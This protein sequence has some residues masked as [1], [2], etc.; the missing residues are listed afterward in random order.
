MGTKTEVKLDLANLAGGKLKD[1]LDE[2]MKRENVSENTR[3]IV[4]FIYD[5]AELYVSYCCTNKEDPFDP[6][7]LRD[8]LIDKGLLTGKLIGDLSKQELILTL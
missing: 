5:N 2:F 1:Y 7:A 8:F 6:K 4:L 3:D